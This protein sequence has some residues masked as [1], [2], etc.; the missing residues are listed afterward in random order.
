M[1]PGQCQMNLTSAILVL[2]SWVFFLDQSQEPLG[3]LLK[4]IFSETQS[5][6]SSH[7]K[8]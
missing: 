6:T 3:R 1:V 4:E 7:I 5:Q 2:G 8:S